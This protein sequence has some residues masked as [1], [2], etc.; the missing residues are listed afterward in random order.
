MRLSHRSATRAGSENLEV[1][2]QQDQLIL[3]IP[4]DDGPVELLT[5]SPRN[6]KGAAAGVADGG[7]RGG[8]E[9]EALQIAV[10]A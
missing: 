2:A 9:E 4:L 10:R 8:P 5:P 7:D 3:A 1:S 6:I